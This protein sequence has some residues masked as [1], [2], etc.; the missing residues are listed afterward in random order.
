MLRKTRR[1]GKEIYHFSQIIRRGIVD[2]VKKD[3]EHEVKN[4]LVK[5]YLLLICLL[6]P[7]QIMKTGHGF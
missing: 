1:F 4:S 2:S 7:F 6:M 5:R 3:Y